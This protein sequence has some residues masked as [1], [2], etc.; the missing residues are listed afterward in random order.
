M[1]FTKVR[2]T[3]CPRRLSRDSYTRAAHTC[4]TRATHTRHGAAAAAAA[5]IAAAAAAATA[6]PVPC[7]GQKW[8][9]S[10]SQLDCHVLLMRALVA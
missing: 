3:F 4:R 6:R 8:N 5:A 7:P 2:A 9:Q 1:H 10:G